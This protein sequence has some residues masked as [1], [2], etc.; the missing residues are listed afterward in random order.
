[1]IKQMKVDPTNEDYWF[2]NEIPE[3][4]YKKE[5]TGNQ[6]PETKGDLKRYDF[7]FGPRFF[8]MWFRGIPFRVEYPV[9][10][11]LACKRLMGHPFILKATEQ[12][13]GTKSFI[14]TWDSM[15]FKVFW[16]RRIIS[17][18]SSNPAMG[19]RLNGIAMPALKA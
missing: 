8:L 19:Y 1:M 14:P 2:N 6:V 5:Y 13:L 17:N 10:K 16:H 4:W 12:L 11:S 15:V 7:N 18:L 3:E 9:D